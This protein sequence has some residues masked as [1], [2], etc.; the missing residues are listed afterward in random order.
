MS[1]LAYQK[2]SGTVFS[3]VAFAHFY[4]VINAIA[5]NIGGTQ[6]PMA[7]SIVVICITGALALWAFKLSSSHQTP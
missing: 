2:V 4:R 5:I 3:I 6:V 1:A 7:A